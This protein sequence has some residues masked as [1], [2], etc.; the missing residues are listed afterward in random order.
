MATRRR[1]NASDSRGLGEELVIRDAEIVTA[2]CVTDKARARREFGS[3]P[4]GEYSGRGVTSTRMIAPRESRAPEPP[5]REIRS[6][7]TRARE[8]TG[9]RCYF[10]EQKARSLIGDA[11]TTHTAPPDTPGYCSDVPIAPRTSWMCTPQPPMCR[12]S[13]TLRVGRGPITA[14][15]FHPPDMCP[16]AHPREINP[17][18]C[19]RWV[20]RVEISILYPSRNF[21]PVL[22]LKF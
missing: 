14:D 11:T 5:T 10:R 18:H 22:N 16:R 17:S 19:T 1:R 8:R 15:A 3:S 6:N 2:A 20:G 4:R 9:Y 21:C 7:R 13:L 12:V